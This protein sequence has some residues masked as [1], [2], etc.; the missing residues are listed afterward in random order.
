MKSF[1]QFLREAS[2]D[3]ISDQPVTVDVYHGSGKKFDQFE[4]KLAKL[5]NDFYGGGIGY[6][7]DNK[8]IA[9]SYARSSS[10]DTKTPHLYHT[11]LTL[12]KP[13]DVDEVFSGDKLTK[14]LPK[15]YDDLDQFARSAGLIKPGVDS[16]TAI[17]NLQSGETQLSGSQVFKGLS[18]GMTDTAKAR[19][20]L[21]K[22]GY[23]GL[24]YNGGM[25]MQQATQH[26]VYIPYS[27]QSI[28]INKREQL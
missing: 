8:N 24:R 2:E 5:K 18:K 16:Y 22:N 21:I 28:K 17:A 19:D 20:H 13:F 9:K 10:R 15:K 11:T 7:T 4:P 6:F 3:D 25:N 27:M 1:K 12:H 23:D 14:I 26:N